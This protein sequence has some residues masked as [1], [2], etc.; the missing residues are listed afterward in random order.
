M[1]L[2]SVMTV[3]PRTVPPETSLRD[4]AKVMR[5]HDVGLLPV[6][7]PDGEVAG[8]VTDRDLVV[9]GIADGRDPRGTPVSE[10]MT[11]KGVVFCYEDVPIEKAAEVMQQRGIRRVL[12]VDH[13]RKLRGVASLADLARAPGNTRLV[14]QTM[15]GVARA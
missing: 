1:K 9:R 11:R 14:G 3:P 2:T 12:V 6:V 7:R 15:E 13:E 5:Q 8:V 10:A 4:A